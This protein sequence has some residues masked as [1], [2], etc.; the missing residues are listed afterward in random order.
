MKADAIEQWLDENFKMFCA[1]ERVNTETISDKALTQ[2]GRV[3]EGGAEV[4]RKHR[5]C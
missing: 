2:D 1:A 3:S 5:D 4:L